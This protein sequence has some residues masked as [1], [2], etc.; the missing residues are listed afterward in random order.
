MKYVRWHQSIWLKYFHGG[1]LSIIRLMSVLYLIII[2]TFHL[3]HGLWMKTRSHTRVHNDGYAYICIA[4]S[5]CTY[6][7]KYK[8]IFI[9]T[10]TISRWQWS[11]ENVIVTSK[12]CLVQCDKSTCSNILTF[13]GKNIDVLILFICNQFLQ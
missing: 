5:K 12:S 10:F 13:L 9:N 4:Y 3:I 6:R 8:Y 1:D 2:I 7:Y 11:D